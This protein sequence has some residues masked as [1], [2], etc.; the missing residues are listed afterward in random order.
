MRPGSGILRTARQ[1]AC[2]EDIVHAGRF[3]GGKLPCVIKEDG[4]VHET[5]SPA[6]NPSAT[7]AFP[8]GDEYVDDE[9]DLIGVHKLWS[10][11]PRVVLASKVQGVAP[12]ARL[13]ESGPAVL[14]RPPSDS[15]QPWQSSLARAASRADCIE[16][17]RL[18]V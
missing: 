1:V 18:G 11:A 8:T 6:D 10:E 16:T 4:A 5:R 15:V 7:I 13:L 17:L 12:A 14:K 9:A 2:G 3:E